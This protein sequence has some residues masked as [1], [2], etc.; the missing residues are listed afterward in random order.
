MSLYCR[1]CSCGSRLWYRWVISEAY[2]LKIPMF[3]PLALYHFIRVGKNLGYH[4][5][6][7]ALNLSSHS[8]VNADF[9]NILEEK[10]AGKRATKIGRQLF[11]D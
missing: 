5:K 7:L 8:S 11:V 2:A 6:L 1:S 9:C 4:N 3:S 10:A